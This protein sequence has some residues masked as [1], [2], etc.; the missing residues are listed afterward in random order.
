M[1]G[2][3][4]GI[5]TEIGE[6]TIVLENQQIGFLLRIPGLVFE[7][8]PAVGEEVKLYTYM[9]VREDAISLF[10]FLSRDELHIFKL[11]LSVSGVGPK[12][13]LGIL[14]VLS[15]RDLR[16]AL[17]TQDA[18]AIAK[19][20]GIGAKTAQ[21]V[22]ID[23]KDKLKL[24]DVWEQETLPAQVDAGGEN[25]V[26]KEA[27]EALTALGYSAAQAASAVKQ[28]EVTEDMTVEECLKQALKYF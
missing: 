6:E 15:G 26:Q 19:A 13:A 20:P 11:L 10:G 21:R 16:L 17:H 8:L 14:S 1:I 22:I 9:H 2:Y 23:L 27:A 28:V 12:G 18:K 7:Q 4:K 5:L 3:I 24:E 25:E